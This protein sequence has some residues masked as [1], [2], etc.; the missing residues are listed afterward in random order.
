MHALDLLVGCGYPVPGIH[1]ILAHADQ[2]LAANAAGIV[3]QWFQPGKFIPATFPRLAP[4]RVVKQVLSR[5]PI[6]GDAVQSHYVADRMFSLR[7]VVV[8]EYC[9]LMGSR[10]LDQ[11][12][13]LS[14]RQP[15]GTLFCQA[16]ADFIGVARADLEGEMRKPEAA[17]CW[18]SALISSWTGKSKR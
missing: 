18:S 4:A 12:L 5:I 2:G 13:V 14:H 1:E 3:L 7:M 15:G 11:G 10:C 6:I 17:S 9:F 8:D 16:L